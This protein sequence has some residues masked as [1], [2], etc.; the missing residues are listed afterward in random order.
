MREGFAWTERG[1]PQRVRVEGLSVVLPNGA[2]LTRDR[3]TG[4]VYPGDR[5]FILR[6]KGYRPCTVLEAAC[7]TVEFT[8]GLIER[9]RDGRLF[10]DWR[11]G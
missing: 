4:L 3:I 1:I 6:G 10:K 8:D 9:Q 11:W 7:F 2:S 5:G